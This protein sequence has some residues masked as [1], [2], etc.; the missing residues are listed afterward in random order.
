MSLSVLFEVTEMSERTPNITI[1]PEEV[2]KILVA[3]DIHLGHNEKDVIRGYLN[4]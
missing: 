4:S 2:I 3:S 1:D